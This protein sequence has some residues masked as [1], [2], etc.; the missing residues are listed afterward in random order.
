VTSI[1][2]LAV[3][4]SYQLGDCIYEDTLTWTPRQKKE[5][6]ASIRGVLGAKR[7]PCLLLPAE[8]HHHHP[9][10][11]K[12]KNVQP[13]DAFKDTALKLEFEI[14]EILKKVLESQLLLL[15]KIDMPPMAF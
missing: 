2:D 3:T 7:K 14:C 13:G 5:K 8:N 12:K 6:L 9:Q 11:K 1:A 10:E 15:G 4:H